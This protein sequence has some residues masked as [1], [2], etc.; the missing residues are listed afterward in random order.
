MNEC[1]GKGGVKRSYKLAYGL[2]LE[3]VWFEVIRIFLRYLTFSKTSV[4]LSVKKS[5]WRDKY[6]DTSGN[7]CHIH[8]L[9]ALDKQDLSDQDFLEF[10]CNL[11]SVIL[12]SYLKQITCSNM[13]TWMFLAQ[14]MTIRTK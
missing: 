14:Y 6:Q 7:L 3:W 12:V 11:Q 8:R 10:I 4:F 1:E 2:I 5:F 13:L 9:V